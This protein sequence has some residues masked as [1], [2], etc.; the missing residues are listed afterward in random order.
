[1]ASW[2]TAGSL[3]S[4]RVLWMSEPPSERK[5]ASWDDGWLMRESFER[6]GEDGRM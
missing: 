4:A 1:M 2:G 5:V 3:V 6:L